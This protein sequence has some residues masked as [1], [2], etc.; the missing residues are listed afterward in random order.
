MSDRDNFMLAQIFAK[1][2]LNVNTQIITTATTSREQVE[3]SAIR[4]T[5]AF[6]ACIALA[7]PDAA[8]NS[9]TIQEATDTQSTGETPDKQ[10][11]R[12]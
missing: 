10:E 3:M 1:Q 2:A 7:G 5:F 4:D 12:A 9:M 11:D 6:C 8:L